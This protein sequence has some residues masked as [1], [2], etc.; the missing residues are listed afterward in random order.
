M[1]AV[2]LTDASRFSLRSSQT[3]PQGALSF[4]R[5]LP[6]VK[7]CPAPPVGAGCIGAWVNGR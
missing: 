3:F 5:D 4:S 2:L 7:R 6:K 1:V